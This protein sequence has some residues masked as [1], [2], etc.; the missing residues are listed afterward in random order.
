MEAP[1]P[2]FPF[3][4]GDNA[5]NTTYLIELAKAQIVITSKV[6]RTVPNKKVFSKYDLKM[7]H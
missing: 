6:L 1:M 3:I 4:H 2:Q 5:N 7:D